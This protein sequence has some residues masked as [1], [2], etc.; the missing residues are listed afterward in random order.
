MKDK[1][2]F[3][4]KK[5]SDIDLYILSEISRKEDYKK[6]THWIINYKEEELSRQCEKEK[7]KIKTSAY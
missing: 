5:F 6:L 3:E 2:Y 7:E 1:D 4:F